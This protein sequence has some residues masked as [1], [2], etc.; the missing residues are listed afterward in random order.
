[1]LHHHQSKIRATKNGTYDRIRVPTVNTPNFQKKF[2]NVPIT[3]LKNSYKSS[4]NEL[5]TE[6]GIVNYLVQTN[7][8]IFN[9]R[10]QSNYLHYLNSNQIYNNIYICLTGTENNINNLL[11]KLLNKVNNCVVITIEA[12]NPIIPINILNNNKIIHW[13]TWNKSYNHGKLTAIPIGLNYDRHYN[14]IQN[15]LN[16]NSNKKY[17]V[18]LNFI[19]NKS[20][21]ERIKLLNDIKNSN[22]NYKII[23]TINYKYIYKII[24]IHNNTNLTIPVTDEK[25]YQEMLPFKFIFSPRGEGEDCHRTWNV[26]I[27]E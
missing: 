15:Y 12:D 1:M 3:R 13:F 14:S 4:K 10:K 8:C 27:W 21:P 22:M 26:Y 2:I 18:G 16:N 9:S 19:P 20:K 6:D 7:N 25:V 17:L 24:T 5:I 11:P 23:P